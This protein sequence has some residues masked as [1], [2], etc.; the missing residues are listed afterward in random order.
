M[1]GLRWKQCE[2]P[3]TAL[4]R[5]AWHGYLAVIAGL[6]PALRD[7]STPDEQVTAEFAA[8]GAHLHV[9]AGL[10]G[11]DGL[12]LVAVAA[13][14]DAMFVA[15]DRTGSMVLTRALARRLFIL[16]RSTPTRSQGG[17][18]RPRPSGAAG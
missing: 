6:A 8:L 16:S 9:H 12:R 4:R 2:Q 18:D 1:R 11:E 17:E 15:G 10:W 14:A 3:V 5:A 7:V 13:R